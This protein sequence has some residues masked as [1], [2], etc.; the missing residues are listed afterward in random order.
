MAIDLNG[1][2]GVTTTGLTSNGIDDNATSTAMT[3]DSSENVLV[4]K[5]SAAFNTD[6]FQIQANGISGAT[7]SA[8][9]PFFVNR[10]STAGNLVDF[11]KDGSTVGSIGTYS[12]HLDVVGDTRGTR[13]TDTAIIPISNSGSVQDNLL[14]LGYSGSRFKDLYLSG[15]VYLGGMRRGLIR[16][17]LISISAARAS[18]TETEAG[19]TQK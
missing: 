8:G 13:I 19:L 12:G 6:G 16:L 2:T 3:I 1:T 18:H 14:D 10:K 4:G 17:L 11:Y 15:G 7:T 5:T 9:R